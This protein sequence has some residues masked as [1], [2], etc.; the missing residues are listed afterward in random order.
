MKDNNIPG[1]DLFPWFAC[2]VIGVI[3]SIFLLFLFG[4]QY[5]TWANFGIG[6]IFIFDEE[7]GESAI[8][9]NNVPEASGPILVTKSPDKTRL[10]IGEAL[11]YLITV[12]NTNHDGDPTDLT[13]ITVT[14]NF[15]EE[16]L[17]FERFS[18]PDVECQADVSEIRC[19]ID[20]LALGESIT[21]SSYFTTLSA[22]TVV[23][24]VVAEDDNGNSGS[25]SS[26]VVVQADENIL[27]LE[28]APNMGNM[29][30]GEEVVFG[31][32][33]T[34]T[35][36]SVSVQ[37]LSFEST[38]PGDLLE[39]VGINSSSG[40]SCNYDAVH[41]RCQAD[42]PLLPGD[43]FAVQ[44]RFQ[45][46]SSGIAVLENNAQDSS[47]NEASVSSQVTILSPGDILF[48]SK[49]PDRSL[50]EMGDAVSFT[51]NIHNRSDSIT[52]ENIDV[53][54]DYSESILQLERVDTSS[55]IDCAKDASEIRCTIL[56]L[57]PEENVS[58]VSYYRSIGS[59]NAYN[60]VT[61]GDDSGQ[62]G[63]VSSSVLVEELGNVFTVRKFP[64]REKINAH[65]SVNFT[66]EITN[67]S[68]SLSFSDV[69]VSDVF[70]EHLLQI[71][72]V[73]PSDGVLCSNS[74]SEIQCQ[75]GEILPGET[76]SFSSQFLAK[77]SGVATNTVTVS[78]GGSVKG[79]G[80]SSVIILDVGN[81]YQL[82]KT[83]N[84]QKIEVDEEVEY[85]IS[86]TN[87]SSGTL[88]DIEII[89]S[90][91]SD[92]LS[93]QEVIPDGFHC[94]ND[95]SEIRC[96]VDRFEPGAVLTFQARYISLSAGVATNT[97]TILN[98]LN[99]D[100]QYEAS[101]SANVIVDDPG[102]IF[103]ISKS[104][105]K[106]NIEVGEEVKYT[107]NI[108]NR[109]ESQVINDV[110]ILDDFPESELELLDLTSS[111]GMNCHSDVS[112]IR[113]N[114]PVM[115]PGD[116]HSIFTT[117]KAVS[118]GT[119]ENT[120]TI[121]SQETEPGTV[122]SVINIEE[123]V[124]RSLLLSSDC[125]GRNIFIDDQCLLTVIA[126]YDYADDK[127]VSLE[128]EYNNF[129]NI[130][131]VA[132]NIFTA[133]KVGIANVIATF[134]SVS[135]NGITL[136]V[137]GDIHVGLDA[138]ENVVLHFP[139]RTGEGND[140]KTYATPI[141]V[142]SEEAK[143]DVVAKYNRVVFSGLG[144]AGVFNWFL[145][146]GTLGTL[147]D[148]FTNELCESSGAGFLCSQ[149]ES[150][151]FE[152]RDTEGTAILRVFDGD[153]NSRDVSLHLLPSSLS[154]IH[155]LDWDGNPITGVL[156]FP[157]Q[158]S[159]YFT[160][161]NIYA[162][163][164]LKEN[165][166]DELIWEFQ[167][168]GGEWTSSSDAG[169]IAQGIFTPVQ[170]GTF[171]LRAKASQKIAFAGSNFLTE[172]TEEIVSDEIAITIG[173]AVPFLD[174]LS[175]VGNEGLAK[176]TSDTLYARIRNFD[177]I[178]AIGE[179]ELHLIRGRY[180]N[181]AD[182]P[183]DTQFFLL[184]L[185]PD[186]ILY[187]NGDEKSVLLEIPFFVPLLDD[188]SQG[189]HTLRLV[190]R[191][192]DAEEGREKITGVL[193]VYI[194]DPIPGDTNLDEIVNLVD[195]VLAMRIIA[196]SESPDSL[197]ILALDRDGEG[198]ITLRDYFEV[199]YRLLQELFQ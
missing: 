55:G 42:T 126:S 143:Q 61:A 20:S 115:N 140:T 138:D 89:D 171:A 59:G 98:R 133:T 184:E 77:M 190:V 128:S 36:S 180:T 176:G 5:V 29:D 78:E 130:G 198:G 74:V 154:N 25:V 95:E 48:L 9:P 178:N 177:T 3:V 44:T 170:T 159:I 73:A 156:D 125:E 148:T 108:M 32:L 90:F 82:T 38:Y 52:M 146:D 53:V 123:A 163:N 11:S 109:T 83:P 150:V 105:N 179:V 6:D 136:N 19:H 110:N 7:S 161:E 68:E 92:I 16:F 75:I 186:S 165:T 158:E 26:S 185:V 181:S 164:S 12:E 174:S 193:P 191:N 28:S 129:Q 183:P 84:K 88:N 15:P 57:S 18:S 67:K 63:T 127:N 142:G 124:V 65:E 144:G 99:G 69:L 169:T 4:G 121:E 101:V 71:E 113:C 96:L 24:E 151:V 107:I 194:G 8:I 13:N 187:K 41:V 93:I 91:P 160:S 122:S 131:T 27:R 103:L 46:L 31:A 149:I 66:V 37:D 22:G 120:V 104:P 51:V 134:E 45:A 189:G 30:I 100:I 139:V 157:R 135:S 40:F 72:G 141:V 79:E 175:T 199:F 50:L 33:I 76:L 162:D 85:T 10:G 119:P 64:D 102:N 195:A 172:K 168:N 81:P 192:K 147:R 21:I 106:R 14:D 114:T 117:Y 43:S 34:N 112:E 153:D 39:V 23:N 87:T 56:S 188:I 60:T 54:D 152:S 97:V 70:S 166:E 173:D 167:F 182:V 111:S 137:I 116:F 2:R 155:I 94:T 132:E 47:S 1:N 62:T 197:Q 17:S 80:N 49:S 86:V 145:E 58:F 196:G 35:H 118:V